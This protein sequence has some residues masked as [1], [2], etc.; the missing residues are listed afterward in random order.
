MNNLLSRYLT[1]NLR[2]DA[3]QLR[4]LESLDNLSALWKRQ[5]LKT[6][7]KTSK[8]L[9]GSVGSGKTLVMDLFYKDISS[10]IPGITRRVHFLEF[11]ADVHRQLHTI[12]SE[13]P[14]V[15]PFEILSSSILKNS[16]VL[17]LD[18]FQLVDIGDS[19]IIRRLF[20]NLFNAKESFL[21]IEYSGVKE[22]ILPP[23]FTL[24][25]T[26]NKPINDLYAK[27][28]N[29]DLVN[30][31][32]KLLERNCETIYLNSSKDYRRLNEQIESLKSFYHPVTKESPSIYE[33]Q[34]VAS[35]AFHTR[36]VS[37][38]E[39]ADF[40]P[41]SHIFKLGN[42]TRSL[43]LKLQVPNLCA[44]ID[45]EVLCGH[46]G[47]LGASDYSRLCAEFPVIF[48][49]GPIRRLDLESVDSRGVKDVDLGRRF[50]N[51]VDVAY[52]SGVRIVVEAQA[53]IE[54]VLS[55]LKE[56]EVN[57]IKSGSTSTTVVK[58][59]GSSSSG[60]ATYIGIMEWSA[61]GLQDAS[62]DKI[63][64]VGI[65]ETGFSVKRAISRLMEMGTVSFTK[66]K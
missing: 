6:V 20:T 59:G 66:N 3:N 16:P 27:G 34:E 52:D 10:A 4:A 8:Y 65:S 21:P 13:S 53:G 12:R 43:Q 56:D 39:S 62:L 64:G 47:K 48:I 40:K 42:T 28:L 19:M 51:F 58:E 24:I 49:S 14:T 55:G 38:C 63:G 57:Q 33:T 7:R 5:S 15:D 32:L 22:A 2:P 41:H 29:R 61:T 17:C 54:E 44:M 11:I 1:L 35:V 23:P 36:F 60:A 25:T 26:S 50:I 37:E 9:A 31:L 18:E 45:F 46:T 30:P